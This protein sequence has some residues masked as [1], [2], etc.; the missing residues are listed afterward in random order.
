MIVIVSVILL[1]TGITLIIVRNHPITLLIGVE[2][3]FNSAIINLVFFSGVVENYEG[4]V[5]ALLGFAIALVEAVISFVFI[6][7]LR[8]R[9]LEEL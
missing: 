7:R 5:L 2:L 3:I 6:Y 4:Y 1:A 8:R 9:K